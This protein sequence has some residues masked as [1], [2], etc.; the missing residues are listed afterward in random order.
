MIL[1]IEEINNSILNRK[2]IK[3][4]KIKKLFNKKIIV[5]GAGENYWDLRFADSFLQQGVKK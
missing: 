5:T 3:I 2:Q 4:K 1:N